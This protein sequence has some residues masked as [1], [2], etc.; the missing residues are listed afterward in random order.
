[1]DS[2][3]RNAVLP[4]VLLFPHSHISVKGTDSVYVGIFLGLVPA[5]PFFA[6]SA[7]KSG[8]GHSLHVR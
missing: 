2:S 3:L 1:M 5:L 7:K 8:K 4:A 6:F